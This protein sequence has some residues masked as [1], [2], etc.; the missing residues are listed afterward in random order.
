MIR[1]KLGKAPSDH[2]NPV[3]QTRQQ[4]VE[5]SA[6]PRPIRRRPKPIARL[7]QEVLRHLNARQ[8]PQQNAMRVN[9]AL[10]R[11]FCPT[12][13]ND[14]GAVFGTGGVGAELVFGRVNKIIPTDRVVRGSINRDN[15]GQGWQLVPIDR[16]CA[17]LAGDQHPRISGTKAIGEGVMR[18]Q[19]KQRNGDHPGFERA[20]MRGGGF[21]A[22]GQV[23]ADPVPHARAAGNQCV[24]KTVCKP[25]QRKKRPFAHRTVFPLVDDGEAIGIMLGPIA[26]DGFANVEKFRNV[27]LK[28]THHVPIGLGLK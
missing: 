13:E 26:G 5:Q 6:N 28:R 24:G 20:Q 11:T 1:V 9:S 19:L 7:W 16:C 2:G 25:I 27:P 18:K 17:C 22:L 8:M 15:S 12:G 4:H 23:Y 10:G 21:N 3:I 14:Q